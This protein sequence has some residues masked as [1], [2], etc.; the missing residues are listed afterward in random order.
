[1]ETLASKLLS[2]E[3]AGK[4]KHAFDEAKMPKW[5]TPLITGTSWRSSARQC[6][7][8]FFARSV[9]EVFWWFVWLCTQ[10]HG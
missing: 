9:C 3:L 8:P 5:P 1:M 4:F 2:R 7:L 10:A 6:F